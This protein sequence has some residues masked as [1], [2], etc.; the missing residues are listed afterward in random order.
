[1]YKRACSNIKHKC[2]AANDTLSRSGTHA[3]RCRV[4]AQQGSTYE[5]ELYRLLDCHR[6][7]KAYAVEVHAVQGLVQYSEGVVDMGRQRW[8]VVL[9]QPARVLIAVQGE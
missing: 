3:L 4:C 9:L 8:D 5:K 2:L 6:C 1:V 7:V